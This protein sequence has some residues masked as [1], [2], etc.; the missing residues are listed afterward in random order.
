[1]NKKKMFKSV[2]FGGYKKKDVIAYVDNLIDA[3]EK[4]IKANNETIATLRLQ[5]KQSA[6]TIAGI[7][8]EQPTSPA[9]EPSA[10]IPAPEASTATPVVEEATATMPVAMDEKMMIGELYCEA[11]QKMADM[12]AQTDAQCADILFSAHRE[13]EAVRLQAE[14]EA[15][16][17]LSEAKHINEVVRQE[18]RL[19]IREE[20]FKIDALKQRRSRIAREMAVEVG[21]L[22]DYMRGDQ[23]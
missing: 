22:A 5:V 10:A 7:V 8:S 13:A 2:M 4:R 20:Q 9:Q 11:S 21:R 23:A 12:V 14:D 6:P 19:T 18:A 17:L 16:K 15:A 1:M 3:F